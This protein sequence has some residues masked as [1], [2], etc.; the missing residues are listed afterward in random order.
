MK[1]KFRLEKV[2]NH[3]KSLVDLAQ[4][5]YWLAQARVTTQLEKINGLYKASDLAR[6]EAGKI[7]LTGG[8]CT[9]QLLTINEFINN[10][11]IKI[12][13]EREQARQLMSIAEEKHEILIERTK[14]L[15]TLEK[16]KERHWVEFKKELKIKEEKNTNDIVVMRSQRRSAV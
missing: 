8:S 6:V 2:M 5:E 14:D 1:F 15:K 3:R 7:A 10:Q 4:K 9:P 13:N 12:Q 16:L 11:K